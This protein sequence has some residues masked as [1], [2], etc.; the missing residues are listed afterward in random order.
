LTS[1]VC[2][3]VYIPFPEHVWGCI[4]IIKQPLHTLHHHWKFTTLH[5]QHT[6]TKIAILKTLSRQ[7]FSAISCLLKV[8]CTLK[9]VLGRQYSFSQ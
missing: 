5:F 8:W 2:S 9:H 4:I 6:R 1:P 3:S 7:D